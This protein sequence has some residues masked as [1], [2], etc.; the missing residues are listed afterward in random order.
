MGYSHGPLF[1]D[2]FMEKSPALLL[3][4]GGCWCIF[5]CAGTE[6]HCTR[7]HHAAANC[8]LEPFSQPSCKG[9]GHAGSKEATC[10]ALKP[11]GLKFGGGVLK[12][13]WSCFSIATHCQLINAS[14][15]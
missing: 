5:G 2:T 6:H 4:K 12:N 8:G 3:E 7:P 14:C 15:N 1:A 9:C 13:R 11:L 10:L